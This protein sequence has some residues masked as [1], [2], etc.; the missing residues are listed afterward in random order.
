M[1]I[2]T[3]IATTYFGLTTIRRERLIDLS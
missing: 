3:K 2:Y 1:K